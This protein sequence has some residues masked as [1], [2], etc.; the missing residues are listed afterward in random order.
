M[1]D[2]IKDG[3]D[4][5]LLSKFVQLARYFNPRDNLDKSSCYARKTVD[6]EKILQ[7][8]LHEFNP[9]N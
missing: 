9:Y 7:H 5:S 8:L 4:V 3:E 2:L 6:A 1:H